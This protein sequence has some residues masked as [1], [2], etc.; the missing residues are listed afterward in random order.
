MRNYKIY[1]KA[2]ELYVTTLLNILLLLAYLTKPPTSDARIMYLL[3]SGTLE[4]A[5]DVSGVEPDI[6]KRFLEV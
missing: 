1:K 3:F 6:T 4:T 2:W 5:L